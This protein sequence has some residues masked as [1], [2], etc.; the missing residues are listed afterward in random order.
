[1][2]LPVKTKSAVVGLHGQIL[3]AKKVFKNISKVDKLYF[4]I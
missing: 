1:M 3:A 2:L 4:A